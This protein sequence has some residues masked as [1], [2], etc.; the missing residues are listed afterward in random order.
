MSE[1]TGILILN[2]P[3]GITSHDCIFKLRKILHMKR[4]GHTG[5]LDP[6]VT[7]VLPIC[8]G[9]ATKVAE[10][11]TDAGKEYVG[12]VTLGFATTTEDQDGEI[13]A[14]KKVDRVIARDEIIRVLTSFIGTITQTPPMY[15]A[16]KVNGKRLYEY[17]RAGIEIDRPS[18]Q[19]Q[20]HEISLLTVQN[21]FSGDQIS[22]SFRV[23][24]SKGTYI[25]TLA[26]MI[27]EKLGFP[28]HMSHLVRTRS[29]SFQLDDAISLEEVAALVE[30]EQIAQVLKPIAT[31]VAHLPHFCANHQTVQKIKN[32]AVL[33]VD[34]EIPNM[35]NQT[36]V[37]DEFGALLGIY[38][39]HPT[40]PGLIKPKKII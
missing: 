10:Y 17:A 18:R 30:Q 34:H 3:A 20:I 14:E 28:A 35:S 9:N 21:T 25:R 22:F 6:N 8:L 2:K 16:V 1:L 38:Q 29:A 12:E 39:D 4:I 15:S 11:I 40:K 23:S 7:G 33:A 31:G 19:V 13:I 24:C 5:T 26:V 36:A 27:G 37:F 32:G